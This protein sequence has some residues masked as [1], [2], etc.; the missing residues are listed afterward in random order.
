MNYQQ[1]HQPMN[2]PEKTIPSHHVLVGS[3]GVRGCNSTPSIGVPLT[4]GWEFAR[5]FFVQIARFLRP[6][7]RFALVLISSLFL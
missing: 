3:K 5:W 2:L 7:E 1:N 4:Q 6:K